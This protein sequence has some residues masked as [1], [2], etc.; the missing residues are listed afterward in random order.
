LA[1]PETPDLF[2]TLRL[3]GLDGREHALSEAWKAGPALIFVGHSGCDT[4]RFTLPYVERLHR[5]RSPSSTVRAVLQDQPADARAL[6]DRLGLTLPV[7]LDP[8]PYPLVSA[9]GLRLVPMVFLVGEGGRVE[10]V[11]E[12]FRRDDLEAFAAR[13]GA[14]AP[15]FRPDDKVPALRPG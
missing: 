2:P 1:E 3:P 12:A 13:L 15:L 6:A 5:G 8:E 14:R 9:L 4:S 7:L 11:S 10:Q